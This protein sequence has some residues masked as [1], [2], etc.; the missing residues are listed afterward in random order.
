M[1][2]SPHIDDG[3]NRDLWCNVKGVTLIGEANYNDDIDK[4]LSKLDHVSIGKWPRD[5]A[6][7]VIENIDKKLSTLKIETQ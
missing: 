5:I 6:D 7:D 4:K 2:Y 1:T 3:V